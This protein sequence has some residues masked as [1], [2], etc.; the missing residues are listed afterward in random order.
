MSVVKR[1]FTWKLIALLVFIPLASFVVWQIWVFLFGEDYSRSPAHFSVYPDS[2]YYDIDPE[3]ILGALERGETNVFTPVSSEEW[4]RDEPYYESIAWTQSDYLKAANALSLETWNEPLDLE[5]WKV[6]DID[7][8]ASCKDNPR[9]FHTFSITYYKTLGVKNWERQYTTRH[10]E[11]FPWMGLVRW[12][13]GAVFSAPMLLGWDGAD[14]S[15]FKITADDALQIAEE[16][17]GLEARHKVNNDC[18]LY[19]VVNQLS[20]LPHKVNWLADYFL[21]DFH[22]HVNPYSDK[23]KILRVGQ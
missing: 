21:A 7:L 6:I 19:L 4:D 18:M 5:S 12:G 3:T 9:G 10:I 8:Q 16:N 15:K 20:P 1:L 2:G 13:N 11:M 23:H 22:I 14:L 17:G